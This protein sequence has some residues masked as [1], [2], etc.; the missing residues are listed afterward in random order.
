M[1]SGPGTTFPTPQIHILGFIKL[2][3]NENQMERRD[4]F[5]YLPPRI[6]SGVAFDLGSVCKKF[7]T[8]NQQN[9]VGMAYCK[10]AAMIQAF[11]ISRWNTWFNY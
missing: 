3:H 2:D 7:K 8:H 4:K 1:A 9:A 5:A 11:W 10:L 6:A